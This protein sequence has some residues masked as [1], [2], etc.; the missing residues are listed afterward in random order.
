MK[1]IFKYFKRVS[2]EPQQL[3]PTDSPYFWNKY[4]EF[5][6]QK[7]EPLSDDN[8]SRWHEEFVTSSI[9]EDK[10]DFLLKLRH[11]FGFLILL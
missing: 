2:P 5:I 7:D 4:M 9:M 11:S 3:E 8:V 10:W 6:L 1:P